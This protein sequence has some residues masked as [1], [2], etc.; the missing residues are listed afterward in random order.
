MNQDTSNFNNEI[1]KNNNNL[2]FDIIGDLQ[3]IINITKSNILIKRL[4]D[5]IIKMNRIIDQNKENTKLIMNKISLLENQMNKNFEKLNLDINSIKNQEIKYSNKRY[6]GQV[7]NGIREGK[8][9]VYF[10]DGDRY[11]GEFINDKAEGKGIYYYKNDD[12]YEGDFKNGLS[13]GKGIMYY[14]D[15]DRY[16]GDYKKDKKEGKGIYYYHNGDR[17]MGD[18]HDGEPIGKHVMLTKDGEVKIYNY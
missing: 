5:I 4:K 15:G 1:Y 7:V 3:Q 11:N 9:I 16:E 2:L 13:E 8:G 14:H 18:Y 6:V 12:R 17:S 10:N